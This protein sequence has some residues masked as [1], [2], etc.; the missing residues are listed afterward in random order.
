[1][2]MRAAQ[3]KPLLLTFDVEEFDMP[4]DFGHPLRPRQ[5]I[6]MTERGVDRILPMLAG[7]NVRA[8]FFITGRFA[9]RRP[10]TVR[11]I[12]GAGHEPA[13]HGLLHRDEYCDMHPV[14]ATRRLRRAREILEST[15]GKRISGVRLPRLRLCP[16]SVIRDAGFEYDATP[17]P[18]WIPGR[19]C[20]L[21]WPRR[22]WRA[23]GIVRVP[24][25][26]LPGVRLPLS[27]CW[28]RTLGPALGAPMIRAAALRAPYVHLYFHP[29]EALPIREAGAPPWLSVG[30]GWTFVDSIQR[31]LVQSEPSLDPMSVRDFVTDPARRDAI[32]E[33]AVAAPPLIG[34]AP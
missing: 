15:T 30:T 11:Q 27:W 3:R 33:P 5:Q 20:G 21:R 16:A 28:Y 1:M 17:H 4:G 12:V 24:I 18:T 14:K 13:V 25:T 19:Y 9:R 23:D 31:L 8:T 10:A 34:V 29:W 7:Q 6:Q 26:V 32:V 2:T 22:P